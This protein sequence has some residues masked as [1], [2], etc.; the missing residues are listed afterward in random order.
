MLSKVPDVLGAAL[1]VGLA[2]LYVSRL[3]EGFSFNY[4]ALG[5]YT[6]LAAVLLVVRRPSRSD[7]SRVMAGVA[8]GTALL[9]VLGFQPAA[10]GW[11]T[12]GLAIQLTGLAGALF[13]LASLGRS[14]GLAPANRGVV[15]RGAYGLVRHP[16]YATEVITAAGYVLAQPSLWND[17][18]MGVLLVGQVVRVVAEER[19]LANDPV[20]Q[21]YC[22]TVRWRLIPGGW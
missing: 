13:S 5:V 12:V 6:L 9:T 21:A 4:L 17:L 10:G 1:W 8:W 2:G 15:T 11:K 20:Y 19:L 18:I 22:A 16:L 3:A 7:G 14:F